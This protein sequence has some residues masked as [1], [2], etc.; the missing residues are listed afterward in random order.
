MVGTK[1]YARVFE[2]CGRGGR[3]MVYVTGLIL[4]IACTRYR[5]LWV[6]SLAI[7]IIYIFVALIMV[8]LTS[9]P[10]YIPILSTLAVITVFFFTA[11]IA[12]VG[13]AIRKLYL[14]WRWHTWDATVR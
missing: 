6:G 9:N 7:S 8:K 12:H 1:V 10:S 13:Y 14:L 11:L 4:G 3:G 5:Y 2:V